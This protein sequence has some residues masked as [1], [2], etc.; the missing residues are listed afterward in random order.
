MEA[1]SLDVRN[2]DVFNELVNEMMSPE[3]GQSA[4]IEVVSVDVALIPL[5]MWQN[6][7]LYRACRIGSSWKRRTRRLSS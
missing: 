5:W 2:Y 1:L 7:T 3:E 6:G 4:V